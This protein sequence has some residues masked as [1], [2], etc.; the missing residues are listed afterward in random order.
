MSRSLMNRRLP[1]SLLLLLPLCG[2]AAETSA[3]DPVQ[4]VTDEYPVLER[5]VPT[6]PSEL[7]ACLRLKEGRV[8][9]PRGRNPSD[10]QLSSRDDYLA[11]EQWFFDAKQGSWLTR[12]ELRPAGSGTHVLVR[13]PSE[14]TISEGYAR[15]ARDLLALCAI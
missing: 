4:A 6:A 3:T 10:R 14:L 5:T 9:Y 8:S 2:A 13:M 15:S 1:G 7:A 11:Y 12:F